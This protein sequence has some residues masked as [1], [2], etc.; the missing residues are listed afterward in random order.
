MAINAHIQPPSILLK[1]THAFAASLLL[2]QVS[3]SNAAPNTI[4]T[5]ADTYITEHRGLG[6]ANSNHGAETFLWEVQGGVGDGFRT[7]PL[8]RFDLS[9]FAGNVVNGSAVVRLELIN[10]NR[11]PTQ[12]V[13]VRTSLVDWTEST[14]TFANF[15]G[16]G[17]NQNAQTGPNLSTRTVTFNGVPE[18]IVFTI[19]STT[20]QNWID[21]PAGN[22]GLIWVSPPTFGAD[23][24]VFSSREG[25]VPPSLTFSASPIPE[26]ATL[27][28]LLA[29]IIT[30]VARRNTIENTVK[31]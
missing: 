23:D 28:L 8:V 15:G 31:L 6:G 16:S 3:P 12:T 29:G 4:T 11:I 19:P 5:I 21:N 1:L 20:V 2:L 10:A 22:F 24:L 9:S 30:L 14:A 18:S 17:F 25:T 13:S 7:Y 26:P 27:N